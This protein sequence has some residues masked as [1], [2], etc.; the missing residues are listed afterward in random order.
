[1]QHQKKAG[2]KT[3]IVGV[4][5][6]GNAMRDLFPDAILYDEP[7]GIGSREEINRC[8]IAFLCVPTPMG[9]E[10][11]CDT[12]AVDRCLSW[13]TPGTIV[14]R[15][16]VPVGYTRRMAEK[17]GK[18]IVFQPE[19]Y[20]ETPNHPL[21]D[22]KK[23]QWIT[24]GGTP[25]GIEAAVRVYETV[26]DPMVEVRTSDSDTAELAKYMEN[27][28]LAAKVTFFNEFYEIAQAMHVD[29]DEAKELFLMDPR[30]NRSHTTVFTQDRGY[31]GSCLPKDMASIIHQ[32]ETL[33][34]DCSLLKA[35]QTRNKKFRE[36]S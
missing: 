36:H 29:Y 20:G 26:Y 33:G 25:E 18:Q 30:M 32:A 19:Y 13:M 16:T 24:L 35:I 10:G 11:G 23:R 34:A 7:K 4:G 31:G 22:L 21:A 1:M 2:W 12:T 27:A 9:P 5:H 15:S 28:F 8:D 14:I 3:G 17:T 6:V